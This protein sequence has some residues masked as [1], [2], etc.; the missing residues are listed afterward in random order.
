MRTLC[1]ISFVSILLVTGFLP[2]SAQQFYDHYL[3]EWMKFYPGR[4]LNLGLH[5]SVFFVEDFSPE[6]IERWIRLNKKMLVTTD[7][8][9]K[10]NRADRVNLRLLRTNLL[11][12][13]HK[14]ELE[15]P[16]VTSVTLY[17]N[18]I[19][20]GIKRIMESDFLLTDEKARLVCQRFS[21]IQKLC[22]AARTSIRQA[23]QAD[24]ERG[25]K[26]LEEAENYLRKELVAHK[27]ILHDVWCS[28]WAELSVSTAGHIQGLIEFLKK[29][30]Q[31][32]AKNTDR[33]L[34]RD[35]YA[36]RLA[37]YVDNNLTPEQLADMA[38]K[39]IEYVRNL[40]EDVAKAYVKTTYPNRKMPKNFKE[41]MDLTLADME[42]D[43]PRN[44]VEYL[45]LWKDLSDAA[46]KFLADNKIVTLPEH[47]T[48][49]IAT[50]P[51]SAGPAA[52]IGWVSSAPPFAPNPLTT[53]YLPS[54][55]DD[56][57]EKE[58]KEFWASF[59]KPFTRMI[60]IHEL[61]PG[62]YL[63]N[64]IARESPHPIRLIFPYG[65]YS[66]GWATFCERVVLDAGWEASRPLSMLAHLR[67]RLENA[68][69][70]YTSVMVHCFGWDREKTIS[71]SVE[72]SLLAPQFAKSLWGRLMDSPMQM[73][74]YFYGSAQLHA[75]FAHEKNRLGSAFNLQRFMDTIL[76][77]GPIPIDEFYGIFDAA[78]ADGR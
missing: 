43:A 38:L 23:E 28:G 35:E 20:N 7:S 67:K 51:E 9:L 53:L 45:A 26:Q 44:N 39:E 46:A 5:R 75:L 14:W 42:T 47:E 58:R 52:R 72:K 18:A 66:E 73:T 59:S 19:L 10:V 54:I 64:K 57:P 13:I 30:I 41:L 27:E 65:P 77:A 16:H 56:F 74:S 69:R 32:F 48:L 6:N 1:C 33:V 25:L 34:G 55:P 4:A 76:R 40:M 50:A 11:T 2:V 70:A 15:K 24:L 78:N 61:Y 29:E 12:E 17:T 8:A 71:F 49:R 68:N 31:P 3:D 63:Q 62:H 36:R 37:L 22:I 60:V 21:S